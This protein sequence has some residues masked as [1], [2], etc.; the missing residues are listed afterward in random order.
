MKSLTRF[1]LSLLERLVACIFLIVLL[2]PLLLIALTI[3]LFGGTPVIVSKELP[4][5]PGK[6][7]RHHYRFRT[8][9]PDGTFLRGIGKFLN[10]YSIDEFPALWNVARGDMRLWDL[11]YR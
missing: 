8:T 9:A 10:L 3:H 11:F 5:M 7:V 6:A 1:L 4:C 2:M